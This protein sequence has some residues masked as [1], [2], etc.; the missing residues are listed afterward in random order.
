MTIKDMPLFGGYEFETPIGVITL[1]DDA[2][3]M[4]ASGETLVLMAGVIKE[5]DKPNRVVSLTLM[6][7]IKV[8]TDSGSK[9]D[10]DV[11]RS[12]IDRLHQAYRPPSGTW[13]QR[14]IPKICK[15]D[16]IRCTHGDEIIARK[17]RRRV[18]RICGRSLKGP[19]PKICFFT[20]EPH[21][22]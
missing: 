6:P 21:G 22:H 18:C 15:H 13:K 17:Y 8:V 20:N 16:D 2:E 5:L 10:A 14:W 3:A 11:A 1:Y 19:I 9:I 7:K 12:T 4:L